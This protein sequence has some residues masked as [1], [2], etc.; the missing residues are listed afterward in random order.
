MSTDVT[1]VKTPHKKETWTPNQAREFAKCADPI[2]GPAYFMEN[3]FYIQH[4]VKGKLLYTP[5]QYQRKLLENYHCYRN[6][7]SL[8][9]RQLGKCLKGS[10]S[11]ID[12]RNK[13]TN[14]EYSIPIG[15]YYEFIK[16][17]HEGTNGPDI[18]KF[19]I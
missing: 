9:G 16:S 17:Q 2:N 11:W 6:S 8:C 10:S 1:L 5:Y 15:V 7:I 12:I 3:Y 4:P 13:S 14:K 19:E 18:E